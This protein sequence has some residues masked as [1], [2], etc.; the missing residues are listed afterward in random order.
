MIV[1]FFGIMEQH[2]IDRMA[3]DYGKAENMKE[4][5]AVYRKWAK[6][7]HPDKGVYAHKE[8]FELVKGSY[9]IFAEIR[10]IAVDTCREAGV[11]M[12]Y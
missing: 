7:T 4:I 8:A 5:K 3:E 11:E 6:K 2:F 10:R 1:D 12:E 9:E